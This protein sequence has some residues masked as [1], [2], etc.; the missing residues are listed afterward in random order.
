MLTQASNSTATSASGAGSVT[1]HR[2]RR[3]RH[4]LIRAQRVTHDGRVD[5]SAGLFVEPARAHRAFAPPSPCGR[6]LPGSSTAVV[7][8]RRRSGGSTARSGCSASAPRLGLRAG[9]SWQ[10]RAVIRPSICT[11]RC[12]C[13]RVAIANVRRRVVGGS[14]AS[15]SSRR[16]PRSFTAALGRHRNSRGHALLANSETIAGAWSR[17][18]GRVRAAGPWQMLLG[19]SERPGKARSQP[20]PSALRRVRLGG[21]SSTVVRAGCG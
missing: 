17:R 1:F 2:T 12:R 14:G 7:R 5:A 11:Y 15:V 8:H 13:A 16:T 10:R 21:E 18:T 9:P 6:S 19:D 20:A 3:T 4:Q